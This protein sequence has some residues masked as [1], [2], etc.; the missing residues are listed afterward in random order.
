MRRSLTLAALFALGCAELYATPSFT[1]VEPA[2]FVTGEP[3]GTVGWGI[4][5]VNDDPNNWLLVT[6]TVFCGPGGDPLNNTCGPNGP[7]TRYDGINDFGPAF[8]TYNDFAATNMDAIQPNTTFS[9]TFNPNLVVPTG[10]GEYII[11]PT[12]TIGQMDSVGGSN[13]FLQYQL[14]DGNPLNPASNP[15]G[16]SVELSTPATVDVTPEPAT[17]AL[18][19]GALLLLAGLKRR[20][21]A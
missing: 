8:G 3:G 12:A 5:I 10:L 16:G 15:V 2:G 19:G 7:A 13:L 11:D 17:L 20:K 9:Q 1:T 14:F 21:R 6:L 4:T 18:A